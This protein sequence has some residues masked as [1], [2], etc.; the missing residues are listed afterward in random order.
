MQIELFLTYLL[1]PIIGAFIGYFTNYVAIRMLFRPLEPWRVFGVR[2]PLTPGVLPARRAEFANRIGRMVGR[3]LLGPN[4]VGRA[5]EKED[6]RRQ[7]KGAV[8]E[9]V[10]HLLERETGSIAS[11]IPPNMRDFIYEII[12]RLRHEA[13]RKAFEYLES[14]ICAESVRNFLYSKGDEI[15]STEVRALLGRELCERIES[16]AAEQIRNLL[17]SEGVVTILG[18]F[19][20]NQTA[21]LF[22]SESTLRELLPAALTTSLVD[23]LEK[24]VFD[25]LDRTLKDPDSVSVV[26]DGIIQAIHSGFGSLEGI[27]GLLAS[28]INVDKLVARFPEFPDRIATEVIRGLEAEKTRG[29]ISQTIRERLNALLDRPLSSILETIP[30]RRAEALRRLFKRKV[31]ECLR[32]ETTAGFILSAVSG[33]MARIGEKPLGSVLGM[34]LSEAGLT[35]IRAKAAESAIQALRSATVKET[36]ELTVE[37]SIEKWFFEH[38][39]GRLAD[40]VPASIAEELGE[41]I[42]L[43]LAELLRQEVPPLVD[44]LNVERIVEEKVNSLDILKMENLLLGIMENHFKY[45]NLFGALLGFLIGALNVVISSL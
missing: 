27:S 28:F 12:I 25:I 13:T 18:D 14:D 35:E 9:K 1:P 15:L 3:H 24:E 32:G 11:L 10:F 2:I 44:T 8:M 20:D 39:M 19:V 6:L 29:H 37:K 21:A 7:L 41:A 40:I 43:H 30:F 17:V 34:T 42:H 45:I 36:L 23:T 16:G 31:M 5:L 4:D 33:G 26:R 38:P 22:N